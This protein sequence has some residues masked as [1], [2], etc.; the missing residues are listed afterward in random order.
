MKLPEEILKEIGSYCSDI[1][2]R[3]MLG[4][5]GSHPLKIEYIGRLDTAIFN[6]SKF[7]EQFNWID[8]KFLHFPGGYYWLTSTNRIYLRRYA[9][10]NIQ[11]KIW[12]LNTQNNIWEKIE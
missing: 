1:D 7:C 9:R 11:L 4:F 3:R 8:R 10:D 5:K 6:A 12:E 2:I